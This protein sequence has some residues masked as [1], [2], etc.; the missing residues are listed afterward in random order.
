MTSAG[1][2][3]RLNALRIDQRRDVPVYVFGI[4]GRLIHTLATVSFAER[5]RDGTLSGYQRAA[6]RKHVKDIVEYLSDGNPLLPNAIV[7]AFDDRIKFEPLKNSQRSEWGTFG[8]LEIPLPRN[9]AETKAGWI[10]DGQQRASALAKL[11]AR[12]HFPVVVVGFQSSSQELQREQFLLVNKTKPLPRD[13]LHE[14][15]PAVKGRLP[16]ELQKRQMAAKVLELVRFDRESPF[17]ERVRGLGDNEE[18]ANISQAAILAVIQNSVRSKGILFD[19]FDGSDKR[20]NHKGMARVLI[21]FYDAVRR[22]WPSAW[23]GNPRTSRLVHGVGIVALG[24]LM[25]RVMREV[26]PTSSKAVS[27]VA[28]RL[29]RIARRC[30]WTAGKWPSLGVPWNELQNTSQDKARLTE[31]LLKEYAAS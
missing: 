4:N 16:R 30:A 2:T 25:D 12:K 21:V 5:S 10:V 7:V 28:N 22:T 23:D 19:Y 14:I 17:F 13:L 26:D 20:H 27:A 15:L 8:H 1:K 24:H 6:V 18:G 3:I 9:G 29:E 31:Y 11:D